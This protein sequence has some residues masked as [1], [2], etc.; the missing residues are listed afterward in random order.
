M[1][2]FTNS[3]EGSKKKLQKVTV[4]I[5][6][7]EENIDDFETIITEASDKFTGEL[8]NISASSGVCDAVVTYTAPGANINDVKRVLTRGGLAFVA[9]RPKTER[10]E[11]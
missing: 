7:N 1:G 9:K 4:P 2:Q 11:D 10:F 5:V 8:I 6:I 3:T